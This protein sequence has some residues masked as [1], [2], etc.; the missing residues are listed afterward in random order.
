MVFT[1]P[2]IFGSNVVSSNP[3]DETRAIRF[4]TAPHTVVNAHPI[5][6]DPSDC[7]AIASTPLFAFAPVNVGS[8]NPVDVTR[9]ILVLICQPTVVNLP[10][11]NIF[12]SGCNASP[13]TEPV[14]LKSPVKAVSNSPVDVRRAIPLRATPFTLEN[15]HPAIILSHC[16]KSALTFA[17]INKPVNSGSS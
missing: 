7:T 17:F 4:L 14:E 9:A 8:S 13:L 3:V 1:T 12:P 6:I 10:P 5:T 15:D 2:L 11:T 16:S